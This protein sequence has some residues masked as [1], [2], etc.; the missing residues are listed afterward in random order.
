MARRSVSSG[1]ETPF[2]V[3]RQAV[4]IFDRC[5]LVAP[6]VRR[7]KI[8][9]AGGFDGS[10]DVSLYYWDCW[11]RM[12]VAGGNA[13]LVDAPLYR[14]RLHGESLGGNRAIALRNR[15]AILERF[16][17]DDRLDEAQRQAVECSLATNRRRALLAE[18]EAA[19]RSGDDS[20]RRRSL[21]V[22]LGSGF[23]LRTR[24]KAFGA[25]LAPRAAGRR[26]EKMEA[27]TGW[28]RLQRGYPRG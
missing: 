13:G 11:I 18:A 6:A 20:A 17:V 5:F 2:A 26:L 24:L 25:A 10:L 28:S 15:V 27:R 21:A 7:S 22:A 16:A 23:G 14:Y 4:E 1:V 9:A 12:I 3:E 8:M 19:L